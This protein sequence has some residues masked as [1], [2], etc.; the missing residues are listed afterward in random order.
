MKNNKENNSNNQEP[1]NSTTKTKF[2]KYIPAFLLLLLVVCTVA[3]ASW[4]FVNSDKKNTGI[5]DKHNSSQQGTDK[6]E[7]GDNIYY[8][9]ET[10][11][12]EE[13][14]FDIY[15]LNPGLDADKK[16][17]TSDD[18]IV[19][20]DEY[21]NNS[22]Y[23]VS[24]PNSLSIF[25]LESGSMKELISTDSDLFINTA[26]LANDKENIA[27][28]IN[29]GDHFSQGVGEIWIYNTNTR[30]KNK[31]F[32][33]SPLGLYTGLEVLGWYPDDSK[34]VLREIGGDG[35]A[36]WGDIHI[37]DLNQPDNIKTVQVEDELSQ[38]FITGLLSPDGLNWLY[39]T[40]PG[41]NKNNHVY[42]PCE[43]GEE[44][45]V[46][47]L[48]SQNYFPVYKN[49][50]HDNNISKGKLRV[51]FS[52]V[53]QDNEN[54]VLSIPDGVYRVNINTQK[55]DKIYN[56]VFHN[57]DISF[58]NRTYVTDI[59]NDYAVIQRTGFNASTGILEL[60]S[61]KMIVLPVVTSGI[62]LP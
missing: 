24:T 42:E 2:K 13:N 51:I 34:L 61:S 12:N 18:H 52:A 29:K 7:Y 32:S 23:I 16:V 59:S 55:S 17:F 14:K 21:K 4:Y 1:Q 49:T 19:F 22:E 20:L 60:D 46:Y 47:N 40:C 5:A 31:V 27:Y 41:E 6:T 3:Y 35:P 44:L 54:I 38:D 39:T 30:S 45:V 26:K 53:W 11:L 36:V 37:L 48:D 25:N 57:P 9:K 33:K 58:E 8:Y 62:L 15:K 43:E 10:F 50:T 56:L 28:S